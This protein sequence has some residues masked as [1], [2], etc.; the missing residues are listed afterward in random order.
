MKGK[1][2]G[3]TLVALI[4]TIIILLILAG[5]T[6]GYIFGKNGILQYLGRAVDNT[7]EAQ[8]QEDKALNKLYSQIFIATNGNSQITINIEDLNKIID[9]KVELKITQIEK[10]KNPTGTIISYMGNH[11]PEGYLIC[12]GS[13]YNIKDYPQLA[14]AN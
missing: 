10:Q 13:V 5:I 6:L 3:I 1:S 4:V 12:D 14:R 11:A 2:K 8:E 9:E 7:I